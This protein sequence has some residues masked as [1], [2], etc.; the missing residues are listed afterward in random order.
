MYG[1]VQTGK[2]QPQWL[3]SAPW[4]PILRAVETFIKCFHRQ[5]PGRWLAVESCTFESPVGRIQVAVGTL[6][7]RGVKFMNYD[8]ADAL[9]AEFQRQQTKQPR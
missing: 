2:S 7:M 8:I 5:G 1:N 4:K 6:V 3:S 9:E